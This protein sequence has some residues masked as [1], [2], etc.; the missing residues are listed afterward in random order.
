MPQAGTA[1]VRLENAFTLRLVRQVD[2]EDLVEPPFPQELR[3]Q[4]RHVVRRGH[5]E[6]GRGSFL[7]PRPEYALRDATVGLPATANPFSISSIHSTIG[8]IAS[9][10]SSA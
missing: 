9:A 6:H 2:E 10:W 3:R 4:V 5:Q 8:A 1:Q 7:H